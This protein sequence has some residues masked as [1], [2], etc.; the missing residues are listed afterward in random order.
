MEEVITKL[1]GV[2]ILL[3]VALIISCELYKVEVDQIQALKQENAILNETL[4]ESKKN[5]NVYYFASK[6]YDVEIELLE[7]IERVETGHYVSDLYIDKN[8]TWGAYDEAKGEYISFD[9]H[10]QST[11]EL[12]RSLRKYYF[13]EGLNTIEKISKKY[14][15]NNSDHWAKQ[16]RSIYGSLKGERQ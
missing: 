11:L 13:N 7:A 16:V 3:V 4:N 14:C 1:W 6:T 2:I 8:N 9:S 10:E 15:P 5:D 12:A